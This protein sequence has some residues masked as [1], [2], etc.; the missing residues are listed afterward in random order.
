MHNV[1]ATEEQLEQ[2][3]KRLREIRFAKKWL[4]EYR[5]TA[6]ITLSKSLAQYHSW[7]CEQENKTIQMGTR[8]KNSK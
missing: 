7:L 2:L 4:Q 8:I 1:Q 3:R 6:P 5:V